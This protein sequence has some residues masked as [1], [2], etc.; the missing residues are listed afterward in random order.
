MEEASFGLAVTAGL[1]SKQHSGN[2]ERGWEG[3]WPRTPLREE[4]ATK[5][6][7]SEERRNKAR[8]RIKRALGLG[9][10]LII[11]PA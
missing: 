10:S 3:R 4:K 11:P 6:R 9:L 7:C 8:G 2:D 1:H 5:E